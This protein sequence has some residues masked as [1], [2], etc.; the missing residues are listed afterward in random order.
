MTT[1]VAMLSETTMDAEKLVNRL[2]D[3]G[4]D[5]DHIYVVTRSDIILEDLPEADPRQYSDLIPAA[6]RGAGVGGSLGLLAGVL[7]ATVPAAGVALS[8]AAVAAV[9][10]GGAALGA[11]MSS[12]VGISLP[13]TQLEGFNQAIRD[14]KTLTLVDVDDEAAEPLLETLTRECGALIVSG[15][16]VDV[17]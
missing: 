4:Y 2:R 8:G 17:A 7:M 16:T 9:T 1:R 3:L 5:D 12:L 15:D 11:W 14:G 6:R 10:A 13:N